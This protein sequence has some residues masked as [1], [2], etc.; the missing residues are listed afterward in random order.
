MSSVLQE[1]DD[2]RSIPP[3]YPGASTPGAPALVVGIGASAGGSDALRQFFGA[4]EESAG[5]AFIVVEHHDPAQNRLLS[6]VLN[7]FTSLPVSA[8]SD[9]SVLVPDRVYV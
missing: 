9:G 3:R 2:R 4:L 6:E 7:G 1:E 5:M 8:L